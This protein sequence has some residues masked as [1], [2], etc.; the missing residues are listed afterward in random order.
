MPLNCGLVTAGERLT[1][2]QR[3]RRPQVVAAEEHPTD[4]PQC[5]LGFAVVAAI[6]DGAD[7]EI[8]AQR[9]QHQ[10]QSSLQV[11]SRDVLPG[12]HRG[13]LG[14]EIDQPVCLLEHVQ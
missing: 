12:G 1:D 3:D 14:G 8:G 10:Q 13:E 9:E 5:G 2:H 4:P 6:D 7:A 11:R